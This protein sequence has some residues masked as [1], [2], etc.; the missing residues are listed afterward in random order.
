MAQNNV[1]NFKK[2]YYWHFLN[3][4]DAMKSA[5]GAE[6]LGTFRSVPPSTS[7]SHVYVVYKK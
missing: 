5:E 1:T 7:G 6:P 2:V 3:C 4:D